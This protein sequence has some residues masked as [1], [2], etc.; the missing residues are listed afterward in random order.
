MQEHTP[1]LRQIHKIEQ[2]HSKKLNKISS[3]HFDIV[4]KLHEQFISLKMQHL[5]FITLYRSSEVEGQ[6]GEVNE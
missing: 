2:K 4:E 1:S 5:F 6:I 3:E